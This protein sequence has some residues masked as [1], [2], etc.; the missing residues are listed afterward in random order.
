MSVSVS[1]ERDPYL[2]QPRPVRLDKGVFKSTSRGVFPVLSNI[3]ELNI[4]RE[5]TV[6][7]LPKMPTNQ[8]E[9]SGFAV[10]RTRPLS[11][12]LST[13]IDHGRHL[14]VHYL[15]MSSS[16]DI[17]F[18]DPDSSHSPAVSTATAE[19]YRTHKR[20]VSSSARSAASLS[21]S[22]WDEDTARAS[23]R[24]IHTPS[25]LIQAPK[26]CAPITIPQGR[27]VGGSNEKMN[28]PDSVGQTLHTI[29]SL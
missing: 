17:L 16:A 5:N 26:F 23:V 3:S 15:S 29:N 8:S 6:R 13:C 19:R 11:R 22:G 27:V 9:D 14:D 12:P 20:R 1:L 28:P 7:F 10:E 21:R 4:R 18:Y 2:N 24:N 25:M